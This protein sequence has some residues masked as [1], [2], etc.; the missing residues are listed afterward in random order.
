MQL[1]LHAP[2][3]FGH[4]HDRII[5]LVAAAAVGVSGARVIAGDADSRVAT[6]TTDSMVT[7]PAARR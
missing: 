3:A 7:E 5:A 2:H 6:S 4:G 1:H